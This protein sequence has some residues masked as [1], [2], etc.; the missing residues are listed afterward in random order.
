MDIIGCRMYYFAPDFKRLS[1]NPSDCWGLSLYHL[2]QLDNRSCS[3]GEDLYQK[4]PEQVKKQDLFDC[5][6]LSYFQCYFKPFKLGLV[7]IIPRMETRYFN[8]MWS[9]Y[10]FNYLFQLYY[11]YWLKL[12]LQGLLLLQMVLMYLK[13]SIHLQYFQAMFNPFDQNFKVKEYSH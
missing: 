9:N 10:F 1:S 11:L 7:P 12:K 4:N 5:F 8:L 6:G 13:D 2:R 3:S